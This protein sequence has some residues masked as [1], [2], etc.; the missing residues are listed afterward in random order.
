MG[1]MP[2]KIPVIVQEGFHEAG[3]ADPPLFGQLVGFPFFHKRDSQGERARG[4][5][6]RIA[7]LG[8]SSKL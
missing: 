7:V 8:L 2:P 3:Q 5:S 6:R 4:F 1:S